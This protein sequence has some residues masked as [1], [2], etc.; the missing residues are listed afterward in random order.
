MTF[1]RVIGE[2]LLDGEFAAEVA[3]F[4]GSADGSLD[5]GLHVSDVGFIDNHL[6]AYLYG[7]GP[8]FGALVMAVLDLLGQQ[9]DNFGVHC[10]YLSNIKYYSYGCHG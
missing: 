8:T 10:C 3:A 9:H 2:V 5:V 6:H 1:G 4:V 7:S